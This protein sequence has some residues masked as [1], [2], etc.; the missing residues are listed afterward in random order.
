MTG[1]GD[2]A[3][4]DPRSSSDIEVVRARL[5]GWYDRLWANIQ[6]VV[7]GRGQQVFRGRG[8]P[9]LSRHFGDDGRFRKW[10]DPTV[11]SRAAP[12]ACLIESTQCQIRCVPYIS[13][14]VALVRIYPASLTLAY[15][16]TP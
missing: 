7:D 13:K 5:G 8:S 4:S 12:H 15:T 2:S 11:A 16:R 9:D 1:A 14:F 3:K 6:I 10:N